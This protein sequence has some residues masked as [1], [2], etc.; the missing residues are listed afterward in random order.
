MSEQPTFGVPE[1]TLG[2]RLGKSLDFAEIGIAEMADYL[3]ISRNT[4]G[5]YVADR[6]RIPNPTLTL[7]AMR[8]GVPKAWIETG[9]TPPHGDGGTPLSATNGYRTTRSALSKAA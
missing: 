5:N 6:T 3:G 1:W 2:D 8:T 9:D 4:V 7:W